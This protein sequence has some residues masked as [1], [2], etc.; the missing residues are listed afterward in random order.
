M[1][2][3]SAVLGLVFLAMAAPAGVESVDDRLQAAEALLL[4]GDHNAAEPIFRAVY[5]ET[6]SPRSAYFVAVICVM[7]GRVEEGERL[8]Q[9]ALDGEPGYAQAWK[10]LGLLY[11]QE[12]RHGE[13]TR[14]FHRLLQLQP[15]DERARLLLGKALAEDGKSREAETVLKKLVSG[16]GKASKAALEGRIELGLLYVGKA[17]QL[18]AESRFEAAVLE[19][20]A[21]K[22][23]LPASPELHEFLGRAYWKT[24]DP[25]ALRHLRLAAE[26]KPSEAAWNAYGRALAEFAMW[27]EAVSFFRSKIEQEPGNSSF[28]ILLGA[29]LWDKTDYKAALEQYEIAAQLAPRSAE[30]HFLKGSG[31]RLLGADWEAKAAW[32]RSLELDAEFRPSL[33]A[34]GMLLAAEGRWDEAVLLLEKVRGGDPTAL[35]V[36]L[37]LGRVYRRLGRLDEAL[38]ELEEAKRL[39]PGE[40]KVYY[41]LGG[42]YGDLHQHAQAR[43]AY[44]QFALMEEAERKEKAKAR[45]Y[46]SS[47]SRQGGLGPQ[48]PPAQAGESK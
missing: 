12:S 30:A 40:K 11:E 29:A 34:L 36:R 32:R 38:Q 37:E 47:G 31:H 9:R 20:E 6:Q 16:K 24:N 7:S 18:Y 22:E 10:A 19:L 14:A 35:P 17:R 28:R 13:A 15:G 8:L 43:K 25:A 5:E 45:P 39:A 26:E 42:V 1:A 44:S 2:M 3:R 41:L 27:D 4:A 23:L 21:A 48:R 33:S 46:L